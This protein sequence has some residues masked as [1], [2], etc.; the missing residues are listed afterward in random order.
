MKKLL[1]LVFLSP[2]FTFGQYAPAAEE[3]GTTAIHKDSSSIISWAN[4]A[5]IKR[6]YLDIEDTLFVVDGS[7]KASFG[8]AL[9]AVGPAEGSPE[10]VVSL[11]DGGEAILFFNGPILNGPGPDLAVFEN[12]FS[13]TYLELA[14]VAVSSDG[15][16]FIEF[17]T[18]SLTQSIVQVNGFG[19]LQAEKLYNF[20]GK[21]KGSYGT[22]FDLEE[23]V[24]SAALDFN[25]IQYVRITD[26]VGSIGDSARYDS[27]G[28]MINDPYP[29][30][31][32][33]G[34][35]DLDG[36]AALNGFVGLEEVAQ[37]NFK[38]FPNP[39]SGNFRLIS[40][41]I[42]ESVEIYD[43]M[44]SIVHRIEGNSKEINIST[45]LVKGTYILS[46]KVNG[47]LSKNVFV[48]K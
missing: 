47:S 1:F 24:D 48:V 3:A 5:T 26:V 27:Q 46:C 44:G 9:D 30:P 28:N 37:L 6:G 43:L 42:I 12:S 18:H 13:S 19:S 11:G 16:N 14:T 45:S 41:S 29:T 23:L 32:P 10:A 39:N 4:Y 35:F 36:V 40:E 25:N 2:I 7:N 34:G 38:L 21:Y 33:S 8:E 20:A 22:P 17:P 31:Y 15:V